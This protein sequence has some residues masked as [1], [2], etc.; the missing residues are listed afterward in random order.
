LFTQKGRN[1]N[2]DGKYTIPF[3]TKRWK[4]ELSAGLSYKQTNNN[5]E[6]G[7]APASFDTL[8]LF[9][10]SLSVAGMRED[11][12]GR[13]IASA[14]LTGSPSN[15]NSRNDRDS[16]YEARIG[17]QPR[18]AYG[19]FFL[20]RNT[21]LTP[22][23]TSVAR[24]VAQVASTNLVPSEQFGVGG[25][26]TVRG[27]EER[28]ISG[29]GGYTFTHELHHRMPAIPLGKHLPKLDWT[30]VFFWD[31]GQI[32]IKHPLTYIDQTGAIVG[33]EAKSAYLASA[34]LGLRIAI[35]SYLSGSIDAA[36]QLEDVETPGAAHHRV[37][38]KFT[39]AY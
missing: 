35:G 3:E 13:W 6:F 7:G 17:A 32:Y 20:Q 24:A 33:H 21:L 27:Y 11:Q 28:I 19:Q 23:D 22:N 18:F 15:F 26:S 12:R 9:T 34:G 37:H 10:G 8:D 30:G 2:A 14:T 38:V 29:D 5:L 31:Y 1:I 36:R 39:L 4:G 16:F 25:V